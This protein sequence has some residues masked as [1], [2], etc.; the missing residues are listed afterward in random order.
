MRGVP[1]ADSGSRGTRYAWS[2]R[3]GPGESKEIEGDSQVL[4]LY[5]RKPACSRNT[6]S[7]AL[8][9]TRTI[10][11]GNNTTSTSTTSRTCS[12]PGAEAPACTQLPRLCATT[13]SMPMQL[14]AGWLKP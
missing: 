9:G 8:Q 3:R 5:G 6:W 11:A 4:L 14:S 1:I 2:Q 10:L 7:Q 12:R 13:A